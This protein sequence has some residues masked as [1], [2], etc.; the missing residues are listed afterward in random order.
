MLRLAC[1]A[2]LLLPAFAA[3]QDKDPIRERFEKFVDDGELPGAVLLVGTK[4]KNV[5]DCV[6]GM[7]N[8]AD[9]IS[10][11]RTTLFRI[12][13][14]TKPITAVAIMM[15]A[16][17]GKLS[18]EDAVEKHLPEFKGQDAGRGERQGFDHTE[19]AEAPH[20]AARLADAHLGD[21]Q[22]PRGLGRP[23]YEAELHARRSDH[24]RLA[25]A[26]RARAR[27]SEWSYNNPGIDTLGRIVEVAI[28]NELRE[29]PADA[30]LRSAR[31]ERFDLLPDR[32]AGEKR[33]PHLRRSRMASLSRRRTVCS[34]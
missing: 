19:E 15:L 14:M 26:A 12:A 33:R 23:V 25:G 3:A 16:D 8:F 20:H 6:T 27:R 21:G 24:R 17:E 5:Y 2:L 32:G 1:L 13:S 10:M 28:G 4:D 7:A 31:H 18:V 22:L 29:V 11:E 9:R 30:H 34:M